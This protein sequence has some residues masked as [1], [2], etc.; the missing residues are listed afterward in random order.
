MEEFCDPPSGSCVLSGEF[1]VRIGDRN[2]TPVGT[3]NM[4]VKCHGEPENDKLL[5]DHGKITLSI[6][7]I[8]IAAI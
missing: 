6:W 4:F 2:S 5:Y 1:N 7:E 8:G 3:S